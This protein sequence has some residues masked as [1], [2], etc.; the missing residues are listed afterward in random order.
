VAVQ[1]GQ[2]VFLGGLISEQDSRGRSGVPFLSRV[3]VIGS[4]FG[5][6]SKSKNRSE[7]LVMITP[8]VVESAVDLKAISEELESEFSRVPP[9]RI[10]PLIKT[11][12]K[13]GTPDSAVQGTDPGALENP[14]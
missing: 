2:T 4:L 7:T 13:G 12:D 10:T 8:T 3:P 11:D 5:S 1:S 6:R 14:D 9:L